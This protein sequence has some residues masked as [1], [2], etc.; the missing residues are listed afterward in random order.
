M[1]GSGKTLNNT[2]GGW[3]NGFCI[4]ISVSLTSN[5]SMLSLVN[6]DIAVAL[7]E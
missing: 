2:D 6:M 1:E 3:D 5:S 4:E 7:N